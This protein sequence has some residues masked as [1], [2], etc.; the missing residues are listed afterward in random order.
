LKGYY[1]QSVKT[2]GRIVSPLTILLKKDAFSQTPEVTK[3]F[4]HLKEA[5]CQAPFLATL[6]FT[7]TF[8]LE[9]DASGMKLVLF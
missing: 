8:N 6:D 4:E 7:K 3:A 9:Y 1:C 5:R 2:Y